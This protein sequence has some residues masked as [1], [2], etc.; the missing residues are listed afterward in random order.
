MLRRGFSD[1]WL[2]VD[3]VLHLESPQSGDVVQLVR[4][5]ACHVGGR[6]FEPRRPRHLT[7]R[8]SD[9]L[10]GFPKLKRGEEA[11][12]ADPK[13]SP[14]LIRFRLPKRADG[15]RLTEAFS[16]LFFP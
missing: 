1:V 5:P 15:A 13:P 16:E 7:H 6:G 9:I 14:P 2:G 4:T 3:C 10:R 12:A 11:R 8:K